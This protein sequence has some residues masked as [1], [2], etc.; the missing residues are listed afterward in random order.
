MKEFADSHIS[1]KM[2]AGTH[3]LSMMQSLNSKLMAGFEMFYIV[4]LTIVID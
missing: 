2:G 3:S 1:Y 4:Y